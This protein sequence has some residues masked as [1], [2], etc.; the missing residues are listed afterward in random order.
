MDIGFFCVSKYFYLPHMAYEGSIGLMSRKMKKN[1]CWFSRFMTFM[2]QKHDLSKKKIRLSRA[3]VRKIVSRLQ[4]TPQKLE[5]LNFGSR[6]FLGQL[7][8]FIL[9][10]SINYFFRV[11]AIQ[12]FGFRRILMHTRYCKQAYNMLYAKKLNIIEVIQYV[13][14][15]HAPY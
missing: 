1:Y 11:A 15:L 7:M 8:H 14:S 13:G 12:I 10:I 4:P 5:S 6:C 3:V 2:A 9:R